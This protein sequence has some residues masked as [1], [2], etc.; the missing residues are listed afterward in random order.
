MSSTESFTMPQMMSL[1]NIK[2]YI[3]RGLVELGYERL[4]PRDLK[5]APLGKATIETIEIDLP[6]MVPINIKYKIEQEV[7]T[8]DLNG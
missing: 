2:E 6:D 4:T 1:S 3:I 7:V 8:I 5:D